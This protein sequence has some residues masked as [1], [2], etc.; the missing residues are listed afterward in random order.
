M[1]KLKDRKMEKKNEEDKDN[2]TIIIT[3]IL[4]S[5]AFCDLAMLLHC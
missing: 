4:S 5:A 2:P 3:K 1:S